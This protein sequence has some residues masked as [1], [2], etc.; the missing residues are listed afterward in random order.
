MSSGILGAVSRHNQLLTLHDVVEQFSASTMSGF[1]KI[2]NLLA[3]IAE[4]VVRSRAFVLRKLGR[5]VTPIWWQKPGASEHAAQLSVGLN[6]ALLGVLLP[7]GISQ[8]VN[9]K[10]EKRLDRLGDA[11][12]SRQRKL[13]DEAVQS[14]VNERR[15]AKG[16]TGTISVL[17]FHC[18]IYVPG[19]PEV[20]LMA[21]WYGEAAADSVSD[22]DHPCSKLDDLWAR[23]DERANSNLSKLRQLE[24]NSQ[25]SVSEA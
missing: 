9:E 25:P 6:V 13:E 24:V 20:N 21:H 7:Y 14:L 4:Q 1:H 12:N 5:E 17:K 10:R 2:N 8:I 3:S 22:G 15:R 23:V 18:H 19:L 11:L 16:R